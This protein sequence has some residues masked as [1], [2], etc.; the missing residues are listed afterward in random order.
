[1]QIISKIFST[2]LGV[3]ITVFSQKWSLIGANLITN[4][5]ISYFDPKIVKNIFEFICILTAAK[6]YTI[7]FSE[8]PLGPAIANL[9]K[10]PSL[11]PPI[12]LILIVFSKYFKILVHF[13]KKL[14]L[15]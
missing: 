6:N 3:K 14:F 2:I 10:H 13:S 5:K 9:K 11:H 7:N 12:S 8:T 15:F 4:V 1:M